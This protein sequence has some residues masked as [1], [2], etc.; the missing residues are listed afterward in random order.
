M[1]V[2]YS[3][4]QSRKGPKTILGPCGSKQGAVLECQAFRAKQKRMFIPRGSGVVDGEWV[5]NRQTTRGRGGKCGPSGTPNR[6][7][8]DITM[9]RWY[10]R[11]KASDFARFA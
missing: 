5:G 10:Q 6:D 7:G 9:R 1:Q 4:R 8:E 11:E 2:R 3:K